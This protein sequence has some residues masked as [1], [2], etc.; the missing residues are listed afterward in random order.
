M[1]DEL[2]R[3]WT[4]E[5]IESYQFYKLLERIREEWDSYLNHDG[6]I[7]AP[8]LREKAKRDIPWLLSEV[9]KLRAENERLRGA[10]ML[11]GEP[12][13]D[14]EVRLSDLENIAYTALEADKP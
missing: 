4:S 6:F 5:N 11:I 10:L 13:K 14:A 8:R 9:E 3:K 1:T 2:P 12:C 7:E